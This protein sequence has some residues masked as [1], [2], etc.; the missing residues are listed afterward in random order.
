MAI[1]SSRNNSKCEPRHH[2]SVG[3]TRDVGRWHE[4]TSGGSRMGQATVEV[5]GKAKEEEANE[6]WVHIDG[7]AT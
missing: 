1:C 6:D 7:I 4:G 5:V 3:Y 2:G